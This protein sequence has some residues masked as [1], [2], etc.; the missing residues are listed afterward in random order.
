M[1]SPV[2]D[3]SIY[4]EALVSYWK[5]Y[6]NNLGNNPGTDYWKVDVSNDGGAN[7]SSIE[8]TNESNNYWLFKQYLI[9]DFVDLTQTIQ[10][11]FIAEDIFYDGDVGTGGSLIEAAIDDFSIDVFEVNSSCVSG[12]LNEDLFVN[13][14]DIVTMV[15]III[16]SDVNQFD[17]YLCAGDLNNDFV[18]NIQDVIILVGIIL[19]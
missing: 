17:E 4:D 19:N 18:I 14:Q 9:S 2:Y 10:F 13:V 7:W 1:F 5:W 11:R 8:N 12:D 15:G 3:L 16:D 6:S